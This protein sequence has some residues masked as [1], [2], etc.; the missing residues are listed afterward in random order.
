MAKFLL[1][2][3]AAAVATHDLKAD[4]PG[5]AICWRGE[6]ISTFLLRSSKLFLAEEGALATA[7]AIRLFELFT[8][9]LLPHNDLGRSF[10]PVSNLRLNAGVLLLIFEAEVVVM[11]FETAVSSTGFPA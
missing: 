11:A 1:E 6:L 7:A 5:L 10:A 4:E 3:A 9:T 8:S 2:G